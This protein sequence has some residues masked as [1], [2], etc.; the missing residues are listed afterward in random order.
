MRKI[1]DLVPARALGGCGVV[2]C[3]ALAGAV[4]GTPAPPVAAATARTVAAVAPAGAATPAAYTSVPGRLYAVAAVSASDAWAVGLGVQN[5]LIMHWNGGQWSQHLNPLGYFSGVAARSASD[6]WAVGGT[7]W[8][9]GSQP[10]VMHWNGRSWTRVSAPTLSGGGVFNAVAANS[11]S[12]AWAVGGIGPGPGI[13]SPALPLIEHW[14]GRHWSVQRVQPVLGGGELIGVAALSATNAWAVGQTGLASEGTGQRTLIEHWDGT[15][16][17]RVA[18]PDLPGASSDYLRGMTVVA[19][20][21][22]WAV[23]S[24]TMPDGHVRTLTAFWNGRHWRLVDSP[25]PGG[26][27]ELLGVTASWV[28]N[29]WAVGMTNP[30]QCGSGAQCQTLIM[31]WTGV[32]WKILP[33]PNPPSGYL[34]ILFGIAAVARDNIWAVGSTDYASTLIVH[35]NGHAWS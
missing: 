25:T 35:W 32:R 9:A 2:A 24:A 22:A 13:P 15:S 31:H 7:S 21:N 33:S 11:A 34:N 18:S 16:W 14:N 26:D 10:L 5:S 19:A 6:V 4:S 3:L 30:T 17:A 27:A 1:T 28:H 23:G 29:I 8:F 20:N 12:N